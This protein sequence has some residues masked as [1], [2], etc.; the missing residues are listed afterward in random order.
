MSPDRVRSINRLS[1]TSLVV[2]PMIEYLIVP[3]RSTTY[4]AGSPVYPRL[5]ANRLDGSSMLGY[6]TP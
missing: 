6:G 1:V 5:A 3:P 4:V 2:E